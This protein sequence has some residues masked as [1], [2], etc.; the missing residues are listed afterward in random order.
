MR[1]GAL[2]IRK[3]N[4][5]SKDNTQQSSFVSQH[6]WLSMSIHPLVYNVRIL[7][8]QQRAMNFSNLL[9]TNRLAIICLRET[10]LTEYISNTTLFLPKFSINRKSRPC[11]NRNSQPGGSLIAVIQTI[12]SCKIAFDFNDCVLKVI[13]MENPVIVK[14]LYCAPHISPFHWTATQLVD[15][16]SLLKRKSAEFRVENIL[17]TGISILSPLV[18]TP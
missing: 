3:E 1:D 13:Q 15:L 4:K 2:L 8:Y 17:V 16:V 11:E 9:S 7:A 10:W 5:W 18:G 14:R 6:E 12:I